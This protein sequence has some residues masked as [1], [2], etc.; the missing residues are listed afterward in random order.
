MPPLFFFV[1][2]FCFPV[3]K[4]ANSQSGADSP[5]KQR[6]AN[7]KQ[8]NRARLSGAFTRLDPTGE[9]TE[10]A[11]DKLPA[12]RLGEQQEIA[13]LAAYLVSDYSSWITGQVVFLDGGESVFAGGEFNALVDVTPKMWDYMEDAIRSANK[14]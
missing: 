12:N 2:F 14:K 6:H 7:T 3:R 8:Q 4:L 11:I 1:F 9:F 10:K 5:Q 13:N